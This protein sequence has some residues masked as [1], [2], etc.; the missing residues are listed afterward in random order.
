M[1]G[2]DPYEDYVDFFTSDVQRL[3]VAGTSDPKRRYIPSK[4]E[5]KRIMKIVR[6]IRKVE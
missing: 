6:G 2:S 3:P 1:P 5:H 4:W